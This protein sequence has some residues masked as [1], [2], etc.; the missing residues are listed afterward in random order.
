M[1][2]YMRTD[3]KMALVVAGTVGH[4]GMPSRSFHSPLAF[5][6]LILFPS[7]HAHRNHSQKSHFS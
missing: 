6:V 4:D 7:S 5:L 3:S 1:L 2:W